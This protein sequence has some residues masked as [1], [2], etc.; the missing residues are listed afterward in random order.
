M[1][2]HVCPWWVGYLLLNPMR[3][4]VQRA[5]KI[6]GYCISPS[7]TVLEI[8]P[9]MGFFS[10]DTARLLGP[11]GR[12]VCVDVQPKMIKVLKKRAEK[13]GVSDHL[14][15]RV[16]STDSLGIDDLAGTVDLALVIATAHEVSDR[17]RLFA[18]VRDSLKPDGKL[19]LAEPKFH[20]K[21]DLFETIEASAVDEGFN[22]I[23]YPRMFRSRAV[24]LGRA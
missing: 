23:E 19:F 3:R 7:M 5:E 18:Q 16:C 24:L 1:A 11:Q 17:Q 4:L 22:V 12:L 10:L 8:G 6:F 21:R 15:A 9:G 2:E 14:D 20:V 13:A